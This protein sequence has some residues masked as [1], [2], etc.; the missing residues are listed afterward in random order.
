MNWML[1]QQIAVNDDL[2]GDGVLNENDDCP[3]TPEDAIVDANGCTIFTLPANNFSIEAVG[4][5][6]P[7]KNNGKFIITALESHNYIVTI[8]KNIVRNFT[9]VIT[10]GSLSPGKFEICIS[11]EGEE[12]EQCFSL[13]INES[14]I[15]L[16]KIS[17]NNNSASV[18][19]DEGTA[20]YKVFLNNK[21]LFST[22]SSKFNVNVNNGDLLEVKSA[23]NCEGVYSK[24]IELNESIMVYPNPSNSLFTINIPNQSQNK[25]LIEVYNYASQLIVSK[26]CTVQFGKISIDLSNIPTGVYI[27]KIYLEQPLNVKIVKN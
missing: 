1:F 3:N 8:N 2:D 6:C 11:V 21:E 12:F 20:P 5:S 9:K 4:E 17:I 7:D 18:E 26:F 22:M 14:N 23:N 19:I 24:H 25:V 10:L 27:A 16:G 13:S 15:V